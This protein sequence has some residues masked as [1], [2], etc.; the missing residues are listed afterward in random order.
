M[1]KKFIKSKKIDDYE[2][3]TDTGWVNIDAIHKTIKYDVIHLIT[4]KF[5]LLCADNHIVFKDNKEE[6]VINLSRGDILNTKDGSSRVISVERKGFSEHM[7]DL[8]LDY[9]SDK[10][11]YTNGILSHNTSYIRYLARKLKRNIIF[12]SPEMVHHITE[13][14]FIPFLMDNS[15]AIL[16]LEDAESA[17]QKRDAL[18]RTGAVSNI[19]N[20]TDG[21]LSDCLNISIVATFNTET[22]NIDDALLRKGR[23]LKAYKFDKLCADKS[24]E[25]MKKLGNDPD[26]VTKN[27]TLADIYNFKEEVKGNEEAFTVTKKVGFGNN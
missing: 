15:D 12:I 14:E 11:Y 27:M 23:L 21:L 3:L 10:R 25:L 13:P 17:L 5:E 6:Y 4:D 20:L 22:K 7:Y 18:G 9:E 8:E 26:E 1:N 19:L 24:R 16:I 2:V